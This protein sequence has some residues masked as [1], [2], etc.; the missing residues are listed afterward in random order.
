MATRKNTGL[1]FEKEISESARVL[2]L[3]YHKLVVPIRVSSCFKRTIPLKKNEYDSFIVHGGHHIGLEL[4]SMALYQDFPLAN[5]APEQ[6][7]GMDKALAFGCSMWLLV[8][9]RRKSPDSKRASDNAVWAIPYTRLKELCAVLP[10]W[11][12]KPRRS[13]PL[14]WFHDSNWFTPLTRERH[15]DIL[16]DRMS[17]IWNLLPLLRHDTVPSPT[18]HTS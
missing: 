18:E 3:Y 11:R 17:P 6:W 4:K 10:L 13:I 12:G 8:N 7:A 2:G 16:K 1:T 15:L 9:M 5:I 14:E